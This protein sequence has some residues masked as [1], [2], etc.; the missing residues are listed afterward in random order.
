MNGV[1]LGVLIPCLISGGLKHRLC[2]MASLISLAQKNTLW[3]LLAT[4]AVR[5]LA[6]ISCL[7]HPS[8]H[9]SPSFPPVP[10]FLSW[11]LAS[12]ME[13]KSKSSNYR[14]LC[15]YLAHGAGAGGFDSAALWV[16]RETR[17]EF[18]SIMFGLPRPHGEAHTGS[19]ALR[20]VC[21]TFAAK[22]KI[23]LCGKNRDPNV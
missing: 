8:C 13:E 14:L 22:E 3:S 16:W 9:P 10:P 21:F 2:L 20:S 1:Y 7:S 19:R 11:Q 15:L 12:R 6:E 17:S 4:F 5:R 18:T 23:G